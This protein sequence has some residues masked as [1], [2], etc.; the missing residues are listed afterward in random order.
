MRRGGGGMKRSTGKFASSVKS[1]FDIERGTPSISAFYGDGDVEERLLTAMGPV[2][3]DYGQIKAEKLLERA[4]DNQNDY[5]ESRFKKWLQGK[6]P[7]LNAKHITPWGKVPLIYGDAAASKYL[8]GDSEK[9]IR[10]TAKL[11]QMRVFPPQTLNEKYLYFK[12][13][14]WPAIQYTRRFGARSINRYDAFNK[15]HN[16]VLGGWAKDFAIMFPEGGPQAAHDGS[17][18]FLNEGRQKS[19]VMQTD[20]Q[21]T[22]VQRPA[23]AAD[24]PAV[25]QVHNQE[26]PKDDMDVDG[27][28]AA[29]RM[30]EVL[31]NFLDK[32]QNLLV[33]NGEPAVK[34][35]PAVPE[36]PPPAPVKVKKEYTADEFS[37]MI[38][39][40]IKAQQQ[41]P[42]PAVE[43]A[44]PPPPPPPAPVAV[45]TEAPTAEEYSE[46]FKTTPDINALWQQVFNSG[47]PQSDK[48]M[49]LEVANRERL[50]RAAPTPMDSEPAPPR[51]IPLPSAPPVEEPLPP[52]TAPVESPPA[53]PP[54]DVPPTT[55][56]AVVEQPPP[57][58]HSSVVTDEQL[59]AESAISGMITD[60]A[61]LDEINH[62][63]N[64]SDLTAGQKLQL[65]GRVRAEQERR[66]KGA[67]DIVASESIGARLPSPPAEL[68]QPA[69]EPQAE[70]E[71]APMP[72]V[73][74]EQ[75]TPAAKT[76][77]QTMAIVNHIADKREVP[78]DAIMALNV[79][80]E[81]KNALALVAKTDDG[82][83]EKKAA[84]RLRHL[85]ARKQWKESVER[86]QRMRR[87]NDAMG[88]AVP[89]PTAGP[90]EPTTP[91]PESVLTKR[92][93]DTEPE[94]KVKRQ[95]TEALAQHVKEKASV[96]EKVEGMVKRMLTAFKGAS[97]YAEMTNKTMSLEQ[98]QKSIQEDM[99]NTDRETAE[100]AAREKQFTDFVRFIGD[101]S[102]AIADTKVQITQ[103]DQRIEDMNLANE[104]QE[105][106]QRLIA[107][108]PIQP[109]TELT[110]A[111]EE[112]TEALEE[113]RAMLDEAQLNE[114]LKADDAALAERQ[115]M[116]AIEM[117]ETDSENLIREAGE[118][119]AA[120]RDTALALRQAKIAI[121][122]E[123]TNRENLIREANEIEV[124]D[125]NKEADL[126]QAR[127]AIDM[128]NTNREND[129]REA[130]EIEAAEPFVEAG[131]TLYEMVAAHQIAAQGTPQQQPSLDVAERHRLAV[132]EFVA[133]TE[134]LRAKRESDSRAIVVFN[135]ND[136][137]DVLLAT[138]RKRHTN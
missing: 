108:P 37:A 136:V 81:I 39:E 88:P 74:T 99:E 51:V 72:S 11:A 59:R 111:V 94:K 127:I 60:S 80:T 100:K 14:V 71:Q 31:S 105:T 109:T 53:A 52:P 7:E 23:H 87:L 133:T 130:A 6:D 132:A 42:P 85:R 83:A 78:S 93:Y 27:S 12:Y 138:S 33:K 32:F 1:P 114:N 103:S 49:L 50:R 61:D 120:D 89:A 65:Y 28:D 126:R 55:P 76:A 84:L 41:P 8:T 26:A 118:V 75:P 45:K 82:A 128:E 117:D 17:T 67:E 34:Q 123:N 113:Y 70:Q 96:E 104:V 112:C 21:H 57:P 13:L 77:A 79:P 119:E 129:M 98:V 22:A 62:L 36:Q 102:N 86:K 63:I 47:L 20:L 35:E 64:T 3:P 24:I 124:A 107:A 116:T 135:A 56:P 97:M 4:V 5:F 125:R 40:E 91:V 92:R 2:D 16:T 90:A 29:E 73:P 134:K 46:M 122:M 101:S 68:P 10:F 54:A 115:A 95:L 18:H 110:G 25:D 43:A 38:G 44:Q 9:Y 30:E 15:E 69:P 48:K 106:T 137:K 66:A 121:D 131:F 58:V 19:P